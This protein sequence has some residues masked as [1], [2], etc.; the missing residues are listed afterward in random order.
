M[1]NNIKSK[2]WEIA[3]KIFG[4]RVALPVWVLTLLVLIIPALFLTFK[5]N[6]LLAS[7][8]LGWETKTNLTSELEKYLPKIQKLMTLPE[9]TPQFATV[10]DVEKIRNQP[11]FNNAQ[12]GDVV[13]VYQQSRKTILYRPSEN[14]IIEVGTLNLPTPTSLP[15][16][17]SAIPLS[18][19]PKF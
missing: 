2:S 1:I 14:K 6:P 7:K 13:L 5:Y 3:K 16:S 17:P 15:A 4:H 10:S 9:E 11:F 18:P 8:V 12:N 19:S